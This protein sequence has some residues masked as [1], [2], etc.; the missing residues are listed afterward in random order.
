[1]EA[2]ISGTDCLRWSLLLPLRPGPIRAAT[3][4]LVWTLVLEKAHGIGQLT[5]QLAALVTAAPK[6]STTS[7]LARRKAAIVAPSVE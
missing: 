5:T 6:A 2:W 7:Y 4:P 1:M 3:L